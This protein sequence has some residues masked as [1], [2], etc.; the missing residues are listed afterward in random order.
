LTL[1]RVQRHFWLWGLC[2]NDE[3]KGWEAIPSDRKKI[4]FGGRWQR[5]LKKIW[6]FFLLLPYDKHLSIRKS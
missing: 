2:G 4:E 3:T 6:N 1:A 5:F